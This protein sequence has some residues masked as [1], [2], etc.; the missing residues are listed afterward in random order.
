MAPTVLTRTIL[1]V[2][3]SELAVMLFLQWLEVPWGAWTGLLDV[4]LPT[5][6][7]APPLYW[8]VFR[9]AARLA[10]RASAAPAEARFQAL[11]DN[12]PLAIVA[13][14]AQDRI[15]MCNPAF[16][17]LFLYRQ[18]EIVGG[19]LD[20][21]I[22]LKE[23]M[24]EAVGFT[25]RNLA[26]E[27]VH[28]TT[29][30]QRKD[31]T[32]V[33]VELHSVPLMVRGELI[34]AY[35]IY[36]DITARKQAEEQLQR[37]AERFRQLMEALPV[38]TRVIQNG[39][40]VFSNPADAVL[41]GYERPDEIIGT[42]ALAYAAEEDLPRLREYMAARAAGKPAPTRYEFRAQR[43]D[44]TL[45]PAE[46]VLTRITYAGE[47]ASLIVL[48]D[49][50]ERKRLHLF[51]SILPVCCLC[52]MVRDDTGTQPGD[53]PWRSLQEYVAERSDTGLSHGFCPSCYRAYRKQQGLEP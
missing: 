30:R 40:V 16:E 26:G 45:F 52:G 6:L 53:G 33:D 18:S 8:L 27:I 51:E 25:Q 29:R 22:A 35:G 20:E 47:P 1:I 38:A 19:N 37:S 50:S 4:G 9:P 44:A 17:R 48:R 31:G 24:S 10:A 43:R 13:L 46:I 14:D 7:T 3:V 36:Q 39:V 12:S 42:E 5:L 28:A 23:L 34:G 2:A 11:I 49:L 32:L 41:F 15:E 21:L